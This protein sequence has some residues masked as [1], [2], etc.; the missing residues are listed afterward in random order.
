VVGIADAGHRGAQ[1]IGVQRRGVQLLQQPDGRRRLGFFGGRLDDL[2]DL[3]FDVRMAADQPFAVEHAQPAEPTE[4]DSEL[5]RHQ[6]VGR[7]RDDGNLEPV[8]VEL[9]GCRDVL[10]GAGAS[11]RHNTD[12]V[13]FVS[14]PGCSAHADL[15]HV[16]HEWSFDQFTGR[17]SWALRRSS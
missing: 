3:G 4:F 12:F 17:S 11:R 16:T 8:G 14:A 2:S 13:E 15:N 1:Q 5:R 6:G 10:R 9:P 7:M